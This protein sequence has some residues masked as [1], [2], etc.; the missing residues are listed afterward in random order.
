VK[1][2][3]G[4]ERFLKRKGRLASHSLGKKVGFCLRGSEVLYLIDASS[5][6]GAKS[7]WP[8]EL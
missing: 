8:L 1:G 7:Y 6:A 3:E 4:W 5:F 2:K